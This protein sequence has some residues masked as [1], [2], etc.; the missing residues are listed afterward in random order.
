MKADDFEKQLERQSFRPIPGAWRDEILGAAN[1]AARAERDARPSIVEPR[2]SLFKSLFWP[3]PKAW[4]T[5]A[6]VWVAIFALRFSEGGDSRAATDLAF[7][8][9]AQV[10]AAIK[11]QHLVLAE[12]LGELEYRDADVPKTAPRPRSERRPTLLIA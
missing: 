7:A 5:L 10:L 6:A 2:T 8:P 1:S 4:A 12:L 3:H 9:A 11:E